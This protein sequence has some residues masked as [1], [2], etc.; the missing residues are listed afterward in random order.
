MSNTIFINNLI[1][2]YCYRKFTWG[3][4]L[5]KYPDEGKFAAPRWLVYPELSAF[6]I[7][8]RMSYG[9]DYALNEPWHTDEFK[10]LFPMPRSWLFDPRKSKFD[11]FVFAGYL[12]RDDAAPKYSK[13]GDDKAIVNDFIAIDQEKEFQV[14]S[15][16][17][18]SIEHGLLLSKY[19]SFDKCN[20][21]ASLEELKEGFPLDEDELQVWNTFKYTV[22]LNLAYFKVMND[23][24]LKRKLLDT[25]DASL[26][27]LSDDEW[28]GNENL[29]GFALMELRDE[30]RRLYEN[31]DLIDWEYTEYLKNKDP[32]EDEPPERDPED[33]QSP[34]YKVIEST[35]CSAS[36]YVRDVNLDEK[37]AGKYEVGQFITERGFVDA[38]SRIGGMV[39]THRY[40]ILSSYM[41]D[42]SAFEENT[43]WGLH[44]AKPNSRFKVMD[45]FT[46]NG[47]TQIVLLQLPDGFEEVFENTVSIER[48][49]VEELRDE[50][51]ETLKLDVIEELA[52]PQWLERCEFPLGMNDEGEF[53]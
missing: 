20:R 38:S 53:F 46:L 3:D 32:F 48:E 17:F 40:L 11:R 10:K 13:I 37:L 12:W 47:K 43:N 8:W 35:L 51:Q 2:I 33:R 25:G 23:E 44:V 29:F 45:I 28:G 18:K 49:M 16:M 1:T 31:E 21:N 9:E 42:F 7:G 34:E 27:Y 36:R 39:T 15:F 5:K 30:I 26:V 19:I 4:N 24:E 41:A 22:C 6:T 52:N 14:D 50:F